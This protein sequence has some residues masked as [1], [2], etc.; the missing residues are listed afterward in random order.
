M[1]SAGILT[2]YTLTMLW[3]LYHV[4]WSLDRSAY[5]TIL[6]F[7]VSEVV[8]LTLYTVNT[9]AIEDSVVGIPDV[10]A[11]NT[12]YTVLFYYAY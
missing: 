1:E 10:I 5:F 12:L 2:I 6:V 9:F 7:L 4:G 11:Q 3:M 8:S